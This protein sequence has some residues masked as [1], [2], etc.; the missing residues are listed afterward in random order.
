VYLEWRTTDGA[1]KVDLLEA[2]VLADVAQSIRAVGMFVADCHSKTGY[3][4]LLH[5]FER[6]A[7]AVGKQDFNQKVNFCFEGRSMAHM[8]S[9]CYSIQISWG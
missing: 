9:L 3:L 4:K 6:H 2:D 1:P 7:R 8:N 5:I